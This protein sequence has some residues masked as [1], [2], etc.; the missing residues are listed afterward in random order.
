MHLLVYVKRKVKMTKIRWIPEM[1][2]YCVL[3]VDGGKGWCSARAMEDLFP[4]LS[5]EIAKSN[6]DQWFYI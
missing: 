5:W 2:K 3:F 4:D 6:P 1:K